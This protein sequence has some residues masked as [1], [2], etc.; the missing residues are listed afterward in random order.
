MFLMDDVAL[1]DLLKTLASAGE[2]LAPEI[3]RDVDALL[4]AVE[5]AKEVKP[6]GGLTRK[7]HQLLQRLR[8]PFFGTAHANVAKKA[9]NLL[10]QKT[11]REFLLSLGQTVTAFGLHQQALFEQTVHQDAACGPP[12]RENIPVKDFQDLQR[13]V[14]AME[15]RG[16]AR[17]KLGRMREHEYDMLA[18]MA[19]DAHRDPRYLEPDNIFNRM[20]HAGVLEAFRN[21]MSEDESALLAEA[22]ARRDEPETFT[23]RDDLEKRLGRHLDITPSFAAACESLLLKAEELTTGEADALYEARGR[24][25]LRQTEWLCKI[26]AVPIEKKGQVEA[27]VGFL[28]SA[29]ERRDDG[30]RHRDWDLLRYQLE[31]VTAAFERRQ[32][33]PAGWLPGLAQVFGVG[34]SFMARRF[35]DPAAFW[36]LYEFVLRN[37]ETHRRLTQ[38]KHA[39]L[40]NEHREFW[41]RECEYL[42]QMGVR[43]TLDEEGRPQFDPALD[44]EDGV[45]AEPPFA[46]HPGA[47]A[48]FAAGEPTEAVVIEAPVLVRDLDTRSASRNLNSDLFGGTCVPNPP[49]KGKYGDLE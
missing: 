30:D 1:H 3:K 14:T 15:D 48:E 4:A 25:W 46:D 10:V 40:E 17:F 7:A 41:K 12:S 49:A 27:F 6:T 24:Q 23:L 9:N 5:G 26:L 36:A 19:A 21:N 39:V 16:V 11:L 13:F 31:E 8:N 28:T 43:Y 35:T 29:H 20:F 18:M 2:K 22:A 38:E 42:D 32:I 47:E 45:E 33:P 34:E 44:E 37:S